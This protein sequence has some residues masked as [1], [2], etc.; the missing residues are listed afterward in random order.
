MPVYPYN[1]YDEKTK[2]NE[3]GI[4]VENT[5]LPITGSV[6]TTV[7]QVSITGN[8]NTVITNTP[9]PITGD[10]QA[11]VSQVSITGNVNTVIVGSNIT[12]NV[13]VVNIP[14]VTIANT[15]LPV[16]GITNVTIVGSNITQNVAV[17]NT[18]I[19]SVNNFPATQDVGI[20]SSSIT[21]NVAVVNAPN[22]YAVQSGTWTVGVDNFPSTQAI[23]GA[24]A[25]NNFPATQDVG[26]VSSS[27]TQNVAVVNIPSVT[28]ANTPLPVTGT[29]NVTIVGSNITQNVSVVNTPNVNVANQIG[30]SSFPRVRLGSVNSVTVNANTNVFAT[31]LTATI[32]GF[33]YVLAESDVTGSFMTV[34]FNGK[35]SYFNNNNY[36]Y[37]NTWYDFAIQAMS[38]DY[39][40]VQFNTTGVVTVYVDNGIV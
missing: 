31:N 14:S 34:I 21:Q 4:G 12:Q 33:I 3:I 7:S 15:P 2:V 28:I 23:T 1:Y 5:P 29:T 8:V 9:I 11:T 39:I 13:S 24:V 36:L 30:I 19:V 16:T 40:N 20:V 17:V 6:Q 10:V 32:N 37:N 38:G 35:P 26:V 22:V 27:I 18:P 25:V